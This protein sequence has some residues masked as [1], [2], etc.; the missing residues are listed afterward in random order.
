MVFHNASL[1]PYSVNASFQA[2]RPHRVGSP[3]VAMLKLLM[4][5]SASGYRM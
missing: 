5:M 4:R 2:P 3:M 1:T